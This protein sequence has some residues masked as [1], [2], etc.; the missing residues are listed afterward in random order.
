LTPPNAAQFEPS[1]PDAS[2]NPGVSS[3]T[4]RPEDHQH[5]LPQRL[6]AA[7]PP[8]RVIR[9]SATAQLA[10]VRRNQMHLVPQPRPRAAAR[11]E[12][13]LPLQEW[14]PDPSTSAAP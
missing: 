8:R 6:P 4:L 1:N 13:R 11:H 9:L 3:D 10:A 7:P 12:V 5:S 14:R 2:L